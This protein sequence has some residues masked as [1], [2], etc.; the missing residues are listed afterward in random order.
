[1]SKVGRNDSCPCGSGKKYK[2]CCLNK[3][4]QKQGPIAHNPLTLM[5]QLV[6]SNELYRMVAQRLFS[7]LRDDYAPVHTAAALS[8]WHSFSTH[9]QPLTKKIGV[10]PAAI[11]YILAITIGSPVTQ[12][13]LAHKYGV[14]AATI[15]Q[16]SFVIDD[17]IF[18]H[19]DKLENIFHDGFSNPHHP[20]SSPA[21]AQQS[22][23]QG[24]LNMEREMLQ[25]GKI[26][27]EKNFSSMDEVNTFMNEQM[28]QPLSSSSRQS[29]SP[30][31][32]AQEMLYDAQEAANPEQRVVLARQAMSI[33]PDSPDAYIILAQDEAQT[34]AELLKLYT[35]GVE[36]G[37]RD[38]GQAFFEENKG[39]FWGLVE[40]RPYMRAKQGLA[41]C[42]A[43][44]NKHEEAIAHYEELLAL[45]PGDNQGVRYMLLPAYIHQ[46]QY[47]QAEQLIQTYNDGVANF[48][49][50]EMLIEYGKH[51]LTSKMSSLLKAAKKANPYILDYLLFHKDTP[52]ESPAYFGIGD[53]NEAII[54]AQDHLHL[55]LNQPVLMKWLQRNLESSNH[56]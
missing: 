5:N 46:K 17:F 23:Q 36:A 50:N 26:L 39:H 55:W 34:S 10:F 44:M 28:N 37:E 51:G 47:A 11:E 42:L 32:Q 13:E 22:L 33:Y 45:N 6:W 25:L 31:E 41:G 3:D 14:S 1:M 20:V 15:S 54:Y 40:T 52:D 30:R 7:G 12:A 19:P 16:R 8:L 56:K 9:D 29:L 43:L 4:A 35:S 48:R 38:L 24:R 21:D 18:D 49:F 27:K 53:E 2:K